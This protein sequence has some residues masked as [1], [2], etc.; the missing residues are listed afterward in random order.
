MKNKKILLVTPIIIVIAIIIAFFI[1]SINN[2]KDNQN[3]G[4]IKERDEKEYIVSTPNNN[5]I[6]GQFTD[7]KI[8]DSNSAITAIKDINNQLNID[9]S[10][11]KFV[12]EKSDTSGDY[13]N[14]FKLKQTYNGLEIYSSELIV[15]T[16][17][18]GNAK[19][20]INGCVDI[21]DNIATSPQTSIN[22]IIDGVIKQKLS[23]LE[24]NPNDVTSSSKLVI[25]PYN[26]RFILVHIVYIHTDL[27]MITFFVN[28]ENQEIINEDY[29]IYGI[30]S[31]DE[32]SKFRDAE[33]G[34]YMYTVRCK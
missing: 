8:N 24:I 10:K 25:Y 32:V 6:S 34:N 5:N 19:G 12:E 11:Y 1:I 28:D 15:Y 9:L 16:D 18:N 7:K 30:L 23:E 29:N 21:K 4:N 22:D 20:L 26:D 3:I 31:L 27:G 33:T 17:K 13:F 14:T 2:N